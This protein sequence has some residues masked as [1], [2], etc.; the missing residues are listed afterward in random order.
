M[1]TVEYMPGQEG[2]IYSNREGTCTAGQY[3]WIRCIIEFIQI[4]YKKHTLKKK[5]M[6]IKTSYRKQFLQSIGFYHD[7]QWKY[8]HR[9]HGRQVQRQHRLLIFRLHLWIILIYKK[10][11]LHSG[12]LIPSTIQALNSFTNHTIELAS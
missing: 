9:G 11:E 2:T 6:K 7:E 12:Y 5:K 1:K 3:I 4:K 10:K 8:E